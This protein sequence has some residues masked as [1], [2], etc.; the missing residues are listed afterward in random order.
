MRKR[1]E[2]V[3]F[4]M[5][6]KDP[7]IFFLGSDLGFGTFKEFQA[8]LPNQFLM[9]G[10]SEAHIIGMAAGLA[11]E[12]KTVFINTI[13]TFITRRCFDQIMI[14][15]GLTNAK[16]RLVG[17]GGGMVYAHLGSTHMAFEDIALTST[18]PGMTVTAP[19]D[20]D[21]ME[22]LLWDSANINGPMYIRMAKGGEPLNSS[23]RPFQ[24]GKIDQYSSSKDLL[25]LTYGVMVDRALKVQAQMQREGLQVGVANVHTLKPLDVNTILKQLSETQAILV[26]EEHTTFGG[27][28]SMVAT[29]VA[30]HAY[31]RAIAYKSMGMPDHFH[32][33]YGSQENMISKYS[34]DTHNIYETAK[35][36]VAK[37]QAKL[38]SP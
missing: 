14:D 35:G 24:I 4:Q 3:I 17:S 23:N 28:G 16:V 8:E 12:G 30:E 11:L 27:L 36:L 6:K 2:E 25:I 37:N 26:V 10:I 31:P 9:E 19:C 13:A 38:N 20:A 15:L 18:V 21:Q 22:K 32:D 29:I 1:F 33:F 7:N 34:L 5:A